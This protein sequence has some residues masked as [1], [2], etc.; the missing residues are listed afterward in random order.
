MQRLFIIVLV[1]LW[2]ATA[3]WGQTPRANNVP[4]IFNR[5]ILNQGQWPANVIAAKSTN[6]LTIWV[7]TSGWVYD[8][9]TLSEDQLAIRGNATS[10]SLRING[11]AA[12]YSTMRARGVDTIFIVGKQPLAMADT[13]IRT[14]SDGYRIVDYVD[15][16]EARYDI[17]SSNQAATSSISLRLDGHSGLDVEGNEVVISSPMGQLRHSDLKVFAEHGNHR[18]PVTSRF[19][20]D[21][22]SI[23]FVTEV[24]PDDSPIVIDPIVRST[25]AANCCLAVKD[26]LE[27][28]GEIY[29]VGTYDSQSGN[30]FPQSTGVY[31]S[32][33]RGNTE[34]FVLVFS[35]DLSRV[36]RGTLIGG[37]A[38]D[39]VQRIMAVNDSTIAVVGSTT[40]AD[41]PVTANASQPVLGGGTDA[42]LTVLSTDLRQ[43]KYS[44]Y[45]GT[46]A[47]ESFLAITRDTDSTV[48]VTGES[49]NFSFPL[50]SS[51]NVGTANGADMGIA[52]YTTQPWRLITSFNVGGNG[53]DQLQQCIVLRDKTV[54]FFGQS[55]SGFPLPSVG[56]APLKPT[57]STIDALI[58]RMDSNLSSIL[59]CTWLGSDGVDGFWSG[60]QKGDGEIVVMG[61]TTSQSIPSM[62]VNALQPLP[63]GG[64]DMIVAVYSSDLS[65]LRYCS[66]LGGSSPDYPH[67]IGGNCVAELPT[68]DIAILGLTQSANFPVSNPTFDNTHNVHD[69]ALTVFRPTLDSMLFATFIGGTDQEGAMTSPISGG[70]SVMQDSTLVIGTMSRSS[71]F[72]T[73]SNAYQPTS[74]GF[75]TGVV[76]TF[77][78]NALRAVSATPS[79]LC[80]GDSVD[81][82]WQYSGSQQ[83]AVNI[84]L[85]NGQ[86]QQFV[87]SAPATARR[88]R[89][90]LPVL[91]PGSYFVKVSVV[92]TG[93][94][95]D[96]A[97]ITVASPGKLVAPAPIIFNA[98][99]DRTVVDVSFIA[100]TTSNPVE[101]RRI[102]VASGD[103]QILST[104]P[105]L[106]VILTSGQPL[107]VQLSA[108]IAGGSIGIYAEL[109]PCSVSDTARI[110][111]ERSSVT[112]RVRDAVFSVNP[113]EVGTLEIVAEPSFSILQQSGVDSVSLQLRYSTFFLVPENVSLRGTEAGVDQKL[114]LN[115]RLSDI[116]DNRIAIP[117]IPLLG[118]DSVTTVRIE[119]VTFSPPSPSR[120]IDGQ[121]TFTGHCLAGGLRSVVARFAAE[122]LTVV[123]N[124]ANTTIAI[125]T[126]AGL[127]EGPY[128]VTSTMG[129]V[130]LSG[131]STGQI[132]V[133]ALPSG[134]YHLQ[135][136]GHFCLLIVQ[137]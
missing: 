16:Y 81:V 64:G 96:S 120:S 19:T 112:V 43:L 109:G 99:G 69:L 45:H 87:V 48:I 118:P 36:L 106:P 41:Y 113:S 26:V 127:L 101:V 77:A 32:P 133:S 122:A 107:T 104:T 111:P 88:S 135:I 12:T 2:S 90:A 82:T 128:I 49:R 14:F 53:N 103:A 17:H 126:N 65:S 84:Y 27:I 121:I 92:G 52:R 76:F 24:T 89:I 13:I 119:L 108:G 61:S 75:S 38:V 78:P 132:D 62:T 115:T 50:V 125:H 25:Y 110:S 4:N 3:V 86:S 79:S 35:K 95:A 15:S 117:M 70:L 30:P 6:D 23:R 105:A 31:T 72:P 56:H 44:T 116:I 57:A 51:N 73:S 60:I 9:H 66:Y 123:P 18:T 136:A 10:V 134:T 71:N 80:G 40:S 85:V 11:T 33:N 47:N 28:N 39:N 20:T 37:S 59:S 58:F 68:G 83:S 21:A 100:Q 102:R 55:T 124:P 46:D 63:Q 7:T 1:V 137:K 129:Q 114:V 131:N 34:G 5:F 42:V 93:G 130:H 97:A 74:P 91:V 98:T 22:S 67:S 54:A 8:Q 29:V 94:S